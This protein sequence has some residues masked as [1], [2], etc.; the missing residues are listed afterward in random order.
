VL[1]DIKPGDMLTEENFA[2]DTSKLVYKLRQMQDA[3]LPK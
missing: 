3:L 2:P 1:K